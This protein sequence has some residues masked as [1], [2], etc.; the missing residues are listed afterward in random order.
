[1]SERSPYGTLWMVGMPLGHPGDITLRALEVLRSVSF[2]AAE[3]T[4]KAGWWFREF[5]ID[6]P[7]LSCHSHN[8]AGRAER[9]I[10]ALSGGSDVAYVSDAGSPGI[11]DPGGVLARAVAEA[12]YRVSPLPGASAVT[13]ALSI[14]G[15]PGRGYHF[16]GFLPRDRSKRRA[17]LKALAGSRRPI[18]LLESPRRVRALLALA[19]EVLGEREVVLCREL[20]KTYEEVLRGSI[21]ELLEALPAAPRGEITLIIGGAGAAEAAVAG[22]DGAVRAPIERAHELYADGLS[23]SQIARQLSRESGGA[24]DRRA[25]YQIAGEAAATPRERPALHIALRGHPALR[26]THGKT[27]EIKR[28]TSL[29]PR[30]TCVIGVGARWDAPAIKSLRGRVEVTVSIGGLSDHFEAQ[31]NPG[32]ASAERIVFRKSRHRS[33]VTLGVA[34]SKGAAD[35]RRELIAL[36]ADPEARAELTISGGGR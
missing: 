1:M 33:E 20:T 2:V 24:L 11:S 27:L 10:A 36:L 9:V 25:A 19:R 7:L 34:A 16:L 12:G 8:E 5:G 29:S 14:C 35:I 18:A 26:A 23:R 17:E 22:A 15:L 6:V 3:D 32:F 30:E 4:R 28:D 31:I 13:A 21:S